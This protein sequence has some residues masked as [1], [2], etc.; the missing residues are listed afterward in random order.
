MFYITINTM[1]AQE[2]SKQQKRNRMKQSTI[3][4]TLI[5]IILTSPFFLQNPANA[6][7]S[8]T[9]GSLVWEKT[10]GGT[11]DDRA[12][13]A[14]ATDNGV[15]VVGST[16]SIIADQTVAWALRL[17]GDGNLLWNKTYPAGAGSEFR[18]IINL[19]DGFLL[20]GNMFPSG[21]EPNGYVVKIDGQGNSQWNITLSKEK[22]NRLFG[23]VKAQD[24]FVLAG[25]T[26]ASEGDGNADAWL[27]KI[28]NNGQ[29]VWNKTFGWSNDDAARAVA[30]A[31][32]NTFFVAGYTDSSGDGNFDFLFLKVDS[33]GN[34]LSNQTYG[35]TESDKAYA[36]TP[37]TDGFVIAGD[38]RSEGAGNSDALIIKIDQTG[39]QQWKRAYGGSDFDSPT[40]IKAL[41]DGNGFVVCGT[42]F[43]FGNGN[44]DFWLLKLD[45]SGNQL[46]SCTVGKAGYEEAYAAV[47][48]SK[49]NFVLAGWVSQTLQG[50]PYDFYVVK[51][52]VENNVAW[53]QTSTFIAALLGGIFAV[54][55][56]GLLLWKMRFSQKRK[57]KAALEC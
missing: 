35:G 51:L 54:L 36:I 19:P 37:A 48:V 1:P 21:V 33:N 12:F 44:R 9:G 56:V 29:I 18:C 16:R 55:V 26:Q 17:D 5:L 34:L 42:T 38:T 53:W 14:S 24:G 57:V 22:I 39:Q 43:S 47:E 8:A 45:N 25:L 6:Q 20:V 30:T 40:Y 31:D 50:Q 10:F 23:A 4:A 49:D 52:L 46:A 13:Y 32:G 2:T 15:L 11:A 7:D 41:S 28:D 3:A 27:T